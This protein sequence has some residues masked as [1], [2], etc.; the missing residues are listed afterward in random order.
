M[1]RRR[2]ESGGGTEETSDVVA[3]RE[4]RGDGAIFF[5]GHSSTNAWACT[6]EKRWDKPEPLG[7]NQTAVINSANVDTLRSGRAKLA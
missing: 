5:Y 6:V 3:W 4:T 1:E 2:R 7:A